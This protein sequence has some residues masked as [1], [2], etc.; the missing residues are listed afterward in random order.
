MTQQTIK[1]DLNEI[2]SLIREKKIQKDNLTISST[3]SFLSII[4]MLEREVKER[5]YYVNSSNT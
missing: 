2:L 5:M 3:S 4:T 1:L